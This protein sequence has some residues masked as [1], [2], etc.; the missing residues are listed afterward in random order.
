MI[1]FTLFLL[2]SLVMVG[3]FFFVAGDCRMTKNLNSAVHDGTE[4]VWKETVGRVQRGI[5][6][7]A[8][9]I[10][11]KAEDTGHILKEGS[12][13]VDQK[14]LDATITAA[15]KM[16]LA[17]DERVSATRIN[18]DT[19]DGIVTLRG[20]VSSQSEAEI[21]VQQSKLVEGVTDVVSLLEI[22]QP[23]SRKD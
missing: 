4:D 22:P 17:N 11:Y 21:A 6:Q 2:A 3:L 12:H 23:A 13:V 20:T 15:V 10:R 19:K 5:D 1:K 14:A 16:R 7:V 9:E 8:Y 18:V